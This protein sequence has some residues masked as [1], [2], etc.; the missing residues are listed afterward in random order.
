[1]ATPPT[2]QVPAPDSK[3]GVTP[4]P[5]EPP[6]GG[7]AAAPGLAWQGARILAEIK[8][9][10]KTV[11]EKSQV[12]QQEVI[13]RALEVSLG[14][15]SDRVQSYSHL[16][17]GAAAQPLLSVKDLRLFIPPGA[18]GVRITIEGPTGY[19]VVRA[20]SAAGPEATFPAEP[21]PDPEGPEIAGQ[22]AA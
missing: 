10:I 12:S 6:D 5:V 2:S 20:D 18:V 4:D 13:T 1:M 17:P 22:P 7:E 19:A 8:R 21:T 11:A 9:N 15:E 14:G 16:E 3:V